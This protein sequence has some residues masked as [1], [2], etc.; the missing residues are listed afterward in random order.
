M[1]T[2]LMTGDVYRFDF[3]VIEAATM[4]EIIEAGKEAANEDWKPSQTALD[5]LM[6]LRVLRLLKI[7]GG[8]DRFKNIV[9]TILQV[10]PAITTYGALILVRH[11]CGAPMP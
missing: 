5:I 4:A 2:A 7:I 9:R 6:V 8:F 1:A 3:L 10:G 11:Y